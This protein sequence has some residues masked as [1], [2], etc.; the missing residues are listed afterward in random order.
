MKKILYFLS[1]ILLLAGCSSAPKK[2]LVIEE[3]AH[4]VK[5][6]SF[7]KFAQEHPGYFNK[8][9]YNKGCSEYHFEYEGFEFCISETLT[10]M[11]IM[12]YLSNPDQYQAN[13]FKNFYEQFMDG[14]FDEYRKNTNITSIL[15][16]Y[17]RRLADAKTDVFN[18]A[19]YIFPNCQGNI[20]TDL[21]LITKSVREFYNKTNFDAFYKSKIPFFEEQLDQ[22]KAWF[23]M[24]FKYFDKIQELTGK[25]PRDYINLI[26]CVPLIGPYSN[27]IDVP[28]GVIEVYTFSLSDPSCIVHELIHGLQFP[29]SM[30]EMQVDMMTYCVV[31]S[32]NPDY[33][34]NFN[35][36]YIRKNDVENLDCDEYLNNLNFQ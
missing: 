33:V 23:A 17:H 2:E 12:D 9:A 10:C 30:D 35:Q 8:T 1:I 32:V 7:D 36:N 11:M 25:N 24:N 19:R 28:N 21:D 31:K 4:V 5:H 29:F 3:P 6:K 13:Y 14:Y 26:Q 15:K 20:Y 22:Y 16:M 27:R 34:W 18:A